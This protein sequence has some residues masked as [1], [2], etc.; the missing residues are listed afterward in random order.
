M[1]N[2][3]LFRTGD[4]KFMNGH[5]VADGYWVTF[6]GLPVPQPI[7]ET[8]DDPRDPYRNP[9]NARVTCGGCEDQWVKGRTSGG[10]NDESTDGEESSG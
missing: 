9:P 10:L 4:D 3:V 5:I 6:C 8:W 1:L 7:R 2:I